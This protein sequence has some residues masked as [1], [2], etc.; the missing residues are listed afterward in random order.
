MALSWITSSRTSQILQMKKEDLELL[1]TA[2]G[3]T[4]KVLILRGK[5]NRMKQ[6]PHAQEN[7]LGDFAPFVETWYATAEPK[8]FMFPAPSRTE[9]KDM[10][11][12]IKEALRHANN[13][14]RLEN[15][16][17]RRGSLQLLAR[18]GAS[19]RVL[20]D[21][22]GHS[23]EATLKRYLN[24]GRLRARDLDKTAAQQNALARVS[25]RSTDS[26]SDSC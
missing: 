17:I 4:A 8:R 16:S 10:L 15:R 3:V 20:L 24:Y 12:T 22:S 18:S 6:E 2:T 9:R 26:G 19:L 13:E 21:C 25:R 14:P 23:N 1:K 11:R 7:E 5:A